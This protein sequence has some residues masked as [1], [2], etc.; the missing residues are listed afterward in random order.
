MSK[1]PETVT[2]EVF[3]GG[4][5]TDSAGN[6]KVWSEADL[7]NIIAATNKVGEAVPA[8]VGHPKHDS[9]AVAWFPKS[10]FVRKGISI[11]AEM[12]N[13]HGKFAKALRDKSFKNRSLALRKD[14]SIRH[15]AM[16]GGQ[17][18]A[19]KGMV[20]FAFSEGVGENEEFSE[21]E[22]EFGENEFS[23]FQTVFGFRTIGRIFQKMRDRKI[24]KDGV[25][26]AN[27]IIEQFEIDGL[28]SMKESED[29]AEPAFSEEDLNNQGHAPN[30]GGEDMDTKELEAKVEKLTS[31][32]SE[33]EK[34]N[35]T[36]EGELKTEKEGKAKVEKEFA[37]H[38]EAGKK[39]EYSEWIGKMIDG[40]KVLPANKEAMIS[41]LTALDGNEA[42]E[43]SEGD[44]KEKVTPMQIFKKQIENGPNLV[45]FGES[46]KDGKARET[47]KTANDEMT[48]LT[49]ERQNSAGISFS[50]SSRQI[51]AERPD[52]VQKL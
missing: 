30:N 28:K 49:I 25:D 42:Q 44:S 12:G 13:I 14:F 7:D 15:V 35:T 18:P 1:F 32:F 38:K 9:K 17:M 37:E 50:E 4:K 34:K 16:L 22:F 20:D 48:K 45:E 19:I 47:T 31:Q 36:L 51:M 2:M 27:E 24:E 43:F 46:F 3:R 29:G 5:Q 6:S 8:T 41:T 23:D 10:K 39:A 33:L 26:K 21:F 40:G 52:L 11:F